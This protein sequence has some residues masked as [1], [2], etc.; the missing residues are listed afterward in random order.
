MAASATDQPPQPTT[1]PE[2]APAPPQ[3]IVP[4]PAGSPA[5]F[6]RTGLDFRLPVPRP[7]VRGVVIDWH[8]HLLSRKHAPGWFEAADH[9]GID[10]FVTMAPLEEALGLQRDFGHRLSFI[11]IP[12]WS[13]F[14]EQWWDDYLRRLE[15]FYNLGSRIVKIHAAPGSLARFNIRLD[16]RRF[17]R[18]VE[19][20]KARDMIMMSHVGDPE[21]WY[22]GKYADAAKFGSRDDHYAAWDSLLELFGRRPWVGAHMGGNPEDLG[23]LQRLLDKHPGLHL[24]I[25]ATRWM[26]REVS[27]RRD[28]MREFFIRNQDRLLFGTDQVSGDDRGFDFLASRFWVHRKLWET[29]YIGPSPIRDPDLSDDAQPQLRGLALPDE[30]IQKL[31]HDNAVRLLE[32]VGIRVGR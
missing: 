8:S 19:E 24:D 10:H 15:A 14:T 2:V 29:A 17:Q 25:S 6:N 13:D 21:A 16:D 22:Q 9:F 7:K 3:R 28:A 20:A 18:I 12:R 4:P 26:Q 27:A 11:V 23:R 32:G 31:Y 1:T 30:V 5:D